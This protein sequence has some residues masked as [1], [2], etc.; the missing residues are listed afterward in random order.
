MRFIK[1][2]LVKIP[3]EPYPAGTKPPKGAKCIMTAKVVIYNHKKILVATFYNRKDKKP[4]CRVYCAKEKYITQIYETG[5]WTNAGIDNINAPDENWSTIGYLTHIADAASERVGL[6]YFRDKNGKNT[7]DAIN[8]YQN[9]LRFAKLAE[10]HCKDKLTTEDV[11]QQLP[12][13]PEDME[14]QIL[15]GPM[16]YSRYLFYRRDYYRNPLTDIKERAYYG[17][18]TYCKKEHLLDWIPKHKEIAICPGCGSEVTVMARGISRSRLQDRC[19]YMVWG[20]V[21][22][23]VFAR[24]FEITRDYSVELERVYTRMNEVERFYF[25]DGQAFKFTAQYDYYRGFTGWRKNQQVTE[26]YNDYY[27]YPHPKDVFIG[28][29]AEHSHMDDYIDRCHEEHIASQPMCYLAAYVKNPSIEH[30]LGCGLFELVRQK[31]NRYGQVNKLVDWK[32]SRPRDMLGVSQ[33]EL[34]K[35]KKYEMNCGEIL[36]YKKLKPHGITL[37]KNDVDIIQFLNIYDKTALKDCEELGINETIRYL[38]YQRRR[39]YGENTGYSYIY[40]QWNDYR[41]AAK[42]LNYD[43]EVERNLFPP[44]LPKAHDKTAKL[45]REQERI[46]NEKRWAQE[47]KE[48]D[49][50]YALLE[51]L[52][53][54]DGELLIRPV[55]SRAE[56]IKEGEVLEHCVASYAN[57]VKNGRTH[58]LFIRKVGYP[59]TPYFT[60]NITPEGKFVQCHGYNN[61]LHIP[62]KQRPQFIKDF[63]AK[64]FAEKVEPWMKQRQK[65][66][67]AQKAK[68]RAEQKEQKLIRVP[69]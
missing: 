45:I 14:Q 16:E 27:I 55:K 21:G 29:C 52:C 4:Y 62:D 65:E 36:L 7:L 49:A 23:A 20:T 12:P 63:E 56:L 58:I 11:M 37:E 8:T 53:Y 51:P 64:W 40:H 3:L 42:R 48:W 43:M 66:Q 28:T 25:S 68:E 67:K 34:E 32:K 57:R 15:D 39:R 13:L 1:K 2:E 17:Y 18:C 60:L 44:N 30:L 10:N 38:K 61:E 6:T 69:A 5:K 35:I 54:T 33:P 19:N 26:V 47:Q 31:T 24:L 50:Q 22:R 46:E 59:D 41:D 9:R